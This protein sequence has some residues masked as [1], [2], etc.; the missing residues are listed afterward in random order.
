MIRRNVNLFFSTEEQASLYSSLPAMTA[1]FGRDRA[2]SVGGHFA[3]L[4]AAHDLNEL[5]RLPGVDTMSDGA[6]Q[7]VTF[8]AGNIAVTG[9]IEPAKRRMADPWTF[10]IADVTVGVRTSERTAR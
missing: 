9:T 6:D 4:G 7:V 3:Q 2:R 10:L 8:R 1:R 5:A